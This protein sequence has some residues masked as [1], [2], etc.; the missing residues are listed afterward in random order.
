MGLHCNKEWLEEL[1]LGQGRL[2]QTAN[3]GA[4]R[5]EP[6]R[7]TAPNWASIRWGEIEAPGSRRRRRREREREKQEEEDVRGAEGCP[8]GRRLRNVYTSVSAGTAKSF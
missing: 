8:D 5:R 3:G 7:A 2:R 4:R 6:Q 1:G